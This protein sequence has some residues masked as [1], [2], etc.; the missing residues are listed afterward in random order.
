[1][2]DSIGEVTL[3]SATARVRTKEVHPRSTGVHPARHS[4]S[5]TR[6]VGQP[7]FRDP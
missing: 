3:D 4:V 2:T 6:G 5:G 7:G 1:M